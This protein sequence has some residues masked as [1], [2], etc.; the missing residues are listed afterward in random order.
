MWRYVTFAFACGAIGGSALDALHTHSGTIVYAR[1]WFAKMAWWTPL[2]FGAT[3]V[4]ALGAY[5]LI[6]RRLRRSLAPPAKPSHLAIGVVVFALLYAASGFL[7]V[8]NAAKL[9]VMLAGALGLFALLG[10][11]LGSIGIALI[12]ATMGS[13]VEA[14]LIYAGAFRYVT[15]DRFGIPMWLPGLYAVGAFALGPLGARLWRT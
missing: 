11:S 7:A 14:S 1:E 2:L 8:S 3:G 10:R 4:I 13:V 5:P 12:A 15:P 6:E 9:F